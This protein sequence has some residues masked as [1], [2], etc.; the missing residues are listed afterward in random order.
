MISAFLE[1]LPIAIGIV[2]TT[3]P[4]AGVSMLL[5][6]RPQKGAYGSFIAGWFL[7]AFGFGIVAVLAS[8]S[9]SSEETS[10]PFWLILLRFALGIMLLVLAMRNLLSGKTSEEEDD[11]D[12]GWMRKFNSMGPGTAFGVGAALAVLNPKNAVLVASAAMTIDTETFGAF[13]KLMALTGFVLV[14]SLGFLSPILLRLFGENRAQKME[15]SFK[16]FLARHGSM[17]GNLV[18][19]ILGFVVI[20]NVWSDYTSG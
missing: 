3:L 13:N 5:H 19:L 12:P 7:A 11:E 16:Q 1:V 6:N 9:F 10:Q 2:V 8:D 4:L 15:A 18:L 20:S 17:I 14:A